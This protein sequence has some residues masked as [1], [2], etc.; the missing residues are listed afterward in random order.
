MRLPAKEFFD[1][2]LHCRH[3]RLAADQDH[4][5][6]IRWLELGVFECVLYRP[7]RTLDE[8]CRKLV[9]FGPRQHHLQMLRP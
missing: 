5:V 7:E 4:L 9:Q 2:I 6:D 8:I 3:P 1:R